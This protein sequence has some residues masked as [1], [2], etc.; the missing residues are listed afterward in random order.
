MEKI[1]TGNY[2]LQPDG[3]LIGVQPFGHNEYAKDFLID[4]M[5][6]DG[7]IEKVHY[8]TRMAYQ[9]LHERGWVRIK[10]SPNTKK[11]RIL[12]DCVDMKPMRNTIDP[13]MNST[14]LRI[15]KILCEYYDTDF[16]DAINDN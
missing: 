16:Y 4:E 1:D 12:G 13:A 11:I 10:F 14:Q 2:W 6:F 3:N 5:G 15:A 9:I 7:Y 8:R